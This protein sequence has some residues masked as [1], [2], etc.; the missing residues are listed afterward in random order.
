[1]IW[2]CRE[3]YHV[4]KINEWNSVVSLW[5]NRVNLKMPKSWYRDW[6][7]WDMA[8]LWLSGYFWSLTASNSYEKY[9]IP[10]QWDSLVID[11]LWNNLDYPVD[12][13]LSVRCFKN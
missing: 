8:N 5:L 13:W 7:T 3:W 11:Y 1:M 12:D 9:G 6:N 10:S 2:S 4:P